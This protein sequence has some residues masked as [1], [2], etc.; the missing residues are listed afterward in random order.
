M[1]VPKNI[2]TVIG[3]IIERAYTGFTYQLLGRDFLTPEQITQVEALGLLVGRR[4]LLEL[5][6]ILVKQRSEERYQTDRTLTDLLTEIF[7]TGILPRL[8]A[9]AQFTLDAAEVSLN[10]LITQTKT[11]LSSAL[12]AEVTRVNRDEQ[13]EARRYYGGLPVAPL[14]E[15]S[16][17]ATEVKIAGLMAAVGLAMVTVEKKFHRDFTE[18]FTTLVNN[19]AVDA[20]FELKGEAAKDQLC[21]K[22]V[23][24]DSRLCF[25]CHAK[26]VAPD[27]TPVI[28][29]L[30][31]LLANG[32]NYG[33]PKDSWQAVIGND[34]PRCRC[35]LVLLNSPI[36]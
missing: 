30:S 4:P 28:Y 19:A 8:P 21:Y 34:H 17:V 14:P 35:Q 23:T 24:N 32:T 5:I 22:L 2:H 6:Y 12:T 20:A 18:T 3:D 27:G 25:H 10:Q 26:Y 33:K 9:A 16:G 13:A 15:P 7:A 36:L 31:E 29:K 11:D 1:L